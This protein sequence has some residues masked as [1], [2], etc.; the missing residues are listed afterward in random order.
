MTQPKTCQSHDKQMPNDGHHLISTSADPRYVGQDGQKPSIWL[1]SSL[2]RIIIQFFSEIDNI[3][4]AFAKPI[5]FKMR[6]LL[7]LGS[8][9][10][11]KHTFQNSYVD[12]RD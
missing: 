6:C 4:W 9:L 5:E 2:A 10:V 7:V 12:L 3:L 1:E 8:K 11:P